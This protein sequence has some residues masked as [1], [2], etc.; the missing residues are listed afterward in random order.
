M[1][2][3]LPDF[4]I[5]GAQKAAS[6]LLM[7]SLRNHPQAWLPPAEEP[8]FRDPVFATRTVADFA[9]AYADRT[10]PRLGLKCP[11][12]L[13]RPEVPGRLADVLGAPDLVVCLRDPVARAVSA[14][15]WRVRWGQLP[16]LPVEVGL[17]RIL[18]GGLRDVDA[19][20]GEVLEWGL[21]G[22]HLER[23]ADLFGLAAMHVL[24]DDDLRTAPDATMRRVTRF[25]G[26]AERGIGPIGRRG[27]NEGVYSPTRL[28]F[29]QCRSRWVLTWDAERTF[30][31]I[32]K[33]RNP[34]LRLASA[35]VAGIDRT[36]LAR[37]CEN[38]RPTLPPD[39]EADLRAY[40]RDDVHRAEELLGRD[41]GWARPV[42]PRVVG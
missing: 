33:P 24:V 35:A 26:L 34:A 4:V 11:D 23:F 32:P 30:A 9:A 41:L 5:I 7:H 6:T 37:V 3:R 22:R 14:Y 1:T 19:S 28:R 38:R 15:F 16:V 29:L 20:V 40:Y 42:A 31:S 8:F 21:Y 13:G 17:R 2:G 39:L 27:V 12:Y 25:L 18:D 36:V 10:E